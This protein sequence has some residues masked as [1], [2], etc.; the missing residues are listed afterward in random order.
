MEWTTTNTTIAMDASVEWSGV[1]NHNHNHMRALAPLKPWNA[2]NQGVDKVRRM[3]GGSRR[4]VHKD[5]RMEN[6]YFYANA[7]AR[8]KPIDEMCD[9]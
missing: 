9:S 3:G 6:T 2:R 7:T 8:K 1:D 4:Y 5:K